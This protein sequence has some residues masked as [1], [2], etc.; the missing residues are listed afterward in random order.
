MAEPLRVA[1]HDSG[2]AEIWTNRACTTARDGASFTHGGDFDSWSWPEGPSLDQLVAGL[3]AVGGATPRRSLELGVWTYGGARTNNRMSYSSGG[4]AGAPGTPIAPNGDPAAVFD[5]LF[6]GARPTDLVAA[7]RERRRRERI[8]ARVRGDLA[9]VRARVGAE[10]RE[11]LGRYES[12]LATIESEIVATPT[13]VCRTPE[14]GG[15]VDA[16]SDGQ[17]VTIAQQ[18]VKL[19][20]AALACDLTRVAS[21][22]F[23]GSEPTCRMTWLGGDAARYNYH[24]CSHT[25]LSSDP[26]LPYEGGLSVDVQRDWLRQTDRWFASMLAMLVSEL[27]AYDPRLLDSTLIVAGNE[28]NHGN[29]H[30]HDRIPFLTIGGQWHMRTGQHRKYTAA[31][32]GDMLAE[33]A[34][35]MG[36]DVATFGDPAYCGGPGLGLAL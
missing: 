4:A 10:D 30:N 23:M 5:Q 35:A 7:E 29:R 17:V 21:L 33:I 31:R 15:A 14:L 18:Q 20:A 12:A 27:E 8:L 1:P 26:S 2:C 3:P 22:M 28:L 11:T 24:G 9:R 32:H 13:S 36:A 25:A 19:I 16:R 6:G 34:R